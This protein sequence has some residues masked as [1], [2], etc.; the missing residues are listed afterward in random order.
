MTVK[1]LN[2]VLKESYKDDAARRL[3]TE[4]GVYWLDTQL[5][6]ELTKVYHD[7]DTDHTIVAHRG[8]FSLGDWANNLM[9]CVA[10]KTGYS[11]TN[12]FESAAQVQHLAERKYGVERLTTVGH[13]QGGLL[14]EMLGGNG[15]E[16]ITYN[17][18]AR[19]GS[20]DDNPSQFNVRHR[21]DVVSFEISKIWRRSADPNK[22][23]MTLD[24]PTESVLANHGL[25]MLE[26]G[27]DGDEIGR[28][29]PR[30]SRPFQTPTTAV[31]DAI[32]A[33]PKVYR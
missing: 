17:R 24:A 2:Q 23:T 19:A 1:L 16:V 25:D 13:S 31:A 14:A 3:V 11:C 32:Q 29:F 10:G 4:Q 20:S 5:S 28:Q 7:F 9:F 15:L 12:R 26:H 27:F 22:N 21:D 6:T 30:R 8:T 33:R 18:A